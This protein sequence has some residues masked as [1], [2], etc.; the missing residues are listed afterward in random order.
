ME[1]GTTDFRRLA[2]RQ[3]GTTGFTK[4]DVKFT[5]S[6]CGK[7]VLVTCDSMLYVYELNHSSRQNMGVGQGSPQVVGAHCIS[8][9]V[10]RP[11]TKISFPATII[12]CSM[13]T[14]TGRCAV[15]V[16]MIGR[17]GTV[18]EI[19]PERLTLSKHASPFT[20]GSSSGSS[21][22]PDGEKLPRPCI[23][24]E[25]PLQQD[26]P[27]EDNRR[28]VYR[29][30][31][32]SRDLPLSVA[33]SARRDCVV[34]GCSTGIEL[35]WVDAISGQ[36]FSRWFPLL[37][38]SDFIYF[39]PA[40]RGRDSARRLRL[41]SSPSG[42]DSFSLVN[43]F[44]QERYQRSMGGIFTA[45]MSRATAGS[46]TTAVLSFVDNGNEESPEQAGNLSTSR[47]SFVRRV[48]TTTA[49]QYRAV[50]ISDGYHILF[51]DPCTRRLGLG[52]DAPV[53]SLTRLLQ[54][55]W[56][57]APPSCLGPPILYAAGTNTQDGIRVIATFAVPKHIHEET[58]N[59]QVVVFYSIPPDL[60]QS[61]RLVET[62]FDQPSPPPI[63]T[64]NE[65]NE[66]AWLDDEGQRHDLLWPL[67]V[68]G[69]VIACCSNLTEIAIEA[70]P[71]MII[72]AF[73]A[74]GVGQCWA[75]DSGRVDI[76]QKGIVQQGGGIQLEK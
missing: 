58:E 2:R 17:I 56:F 53:G 45:A 20:S 44:G 14:T 70:S 1:V 8:L 59:K 50:P 33:L 73:N 47:G 4:G 9:G 13:D 74:D 31:C 55:V 26:M 11:V 76:P 63:L 24:T 40:R 10:L 3:D 27:Q 12:A 30:I 65:A 19:M 41:I 54:K 67:E 5:V 69:K 37:S 16:L 23:C 51:T 48:S 64:T 57:R 7:F 60:F 43:G 52:T 36:D 71:D 22:P 61:E 6:Q 25:T 15:A 29:N 35:H 38:P 42:N 72:W 34:F 49:E 66:W 21:S 18:Y 28:S 62:I 68:D 75:M 46:G 39:V 32:H